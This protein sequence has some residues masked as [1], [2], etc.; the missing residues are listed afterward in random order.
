MEKLLWSCLGSSQGHLR[1]IS[2]KREAR[3]RLLQ[4]SDE[5]IPA[6]ESKCVKCTG[7]EAAW[8]PL[9]HQLEY[10]NVNLGRSSEALTRWIIREFLHRL[11]V[12]TA[13]SSSAHL[14]LFVEGWPYRAP[15]CLIARTIA[16]AKQLCR[17]KAKQQ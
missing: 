12:D 3:I 17:E 15:W 7:L 13:L 14:I 1:Y 10:E 9:F 5:R 2:T 11:K 6:I 16:S 8:S 4:I